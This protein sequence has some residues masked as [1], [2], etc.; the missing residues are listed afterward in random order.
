MKPG[1]D[2][3]A[4]VWGVISEQLEVDKKDIQPESKLIDDL[5]ADSLAIVEIM[6]CIEEEF[7]LEFDLDDPPPD[8]D[9]DKV[10]T[11]QDIVDYLGK[12]QKRA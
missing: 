9:I 1:L 7:E 2:I 6:L 8:A 4:V 5:G 11:V 10:A 3:K 12:L